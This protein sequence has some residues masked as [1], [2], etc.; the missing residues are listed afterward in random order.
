[1]AKPARV[2]GCRECT[3]LVTMAALFVLGLLLYYALA[4][5]RREHGYS[6]LSRLLVLLYLGLGVSAT[7]L[8]VADVLSPVF[9]PNYLASGFLLLCIL[10]SITGFLS[11]RARHFG[12][13]IA[14]LRHQRLIE[15]VLI[16]SQL[17]AI[18]FFLPFAVGSFTGDANENRLELMSKMEVLGSY[19]LFNTLAGAASQLFGISL[20]MAGVRLSRP[21]LRG[22]GS[23]RAALLILASLSYVVYI[24]AYVGR[25]GIAYWMMTA[26]AVYV[27]FRPHM[28]NPLRRRIVAAGAML[29][30]LML[31]PFLTITL[32]RFVDSDLGS[33][34]SVLDY[35]GS[36]IN[37]FSDYSSID[38]PLTFGIMNFPMFVVPLCPVVG[39]VCDNWETL[40]EGVFALYLEQGKPPW[41]FGTFVS[42][43]VGDFGYVGALL[44]VALLAWTSHRLCRRRP[45]NPPTLV[46]LLLILFM[47]LVPYWGVFYFRFSI[48]NGFI[49]V[50]LLFILFVHLLQKAP[51]SR[52]RTALMGPRHLTQ[53]LRSSR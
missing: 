37:T 13:A 12:H 10:V 51:V 19:G 27:V 30:M 35:F 46:R 52:Y 26:L 53:R 14:S 9:P 15:N 25:D 31:I 32:A 24:L 22:Q 2:I 50:N 39:L 17:Y 20:V 4:T 45:G 18:L 23:R 5:L 49:V 7:L 44:L 28:P 6:E 47:F 16:S 42:D 34:W 48:A 21:S 43:F 1:M 40:K 11:F 8:A 29:G 41:L 36:Q 33:A 3:G 38:R